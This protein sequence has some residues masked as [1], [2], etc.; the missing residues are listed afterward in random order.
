MKTQLKLLLLAL[1][2]LCLLS[3]TRDIAFSNKESIEDDSLMASVEDLDPSTI[4]DLLNEMKKGSLKR[5]FP[6]KIEAETNWQL[7]S[8]AHFIWIGSV[9]P[10]KYVK[11][12][13][14][15]CQHNLE[16][17]V[18]GKGLSQSG[19]IHPFGIYIFR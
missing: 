13:N 7:E 15:F 5:E 19:Q 1:V 3:F 17:Q 8:L 9:L 16:Y 18:F 4:T 2:L 14:K 12:I 10:D 6:I 11:N